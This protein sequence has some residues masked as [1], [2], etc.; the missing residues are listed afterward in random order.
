VTRLAL[1]VLALLALAAPAAAHLKPT[2]LPV[3]GGPPFFT[4][5]I[6]ASNVEH[7]GVLPLSTDSPGARLLGKHFYITTERDLT[8]YDVSN[9]TAPVELSR[10]LLT[11]APGQYYFPEEDVDTNGSVL[12]TSEA[13]AV[14][15]YDVSDKK[16]VK[17]VS[18]LEGDAQHTI[19]CVLD[20][21]WAYGSEG[22]IID[23]TD[24]K[25]PKVAGNW[26]TTYATTSRHDVTEVAPG[27]VLTASQPM[28]LLD[29]REDPA[30]PKLLARIANEDDRFQH[31]TLWPNQMQDKYA[32][33]GGEGSG[34]ACEESV[35]STFQTYDTT[36][37]ETSGT[38]RE[39]DQ[40]RVL[41][42]TFADGR[43]PTSQFCVHWFTP[44]PKYRNGGLVAISWYEHGTRIL[45][46]GGD[47]SI[48]EVGHVITP[49][50]SASAAYWIS[51]DVF[52]VAD[53]NRGLDIFKYTGPQPAAKK[54]KKPKK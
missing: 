32:L 51:D 50:S 42:G 3:L 52:Y 53:Y 4:P 11:D 22:S 16:D 24:P 35:D 29:A 30:K 23:L 44:H 6:T 26:E 20:C 19:S 1:A 25:A 21:T 14:E 28:Y 15:V 43:A 12:L 39:V 13:G 31:A 54:A 40:F 46:I 5:P 36:G 17:L 47:G 37:W 2:P 49:G 48:K 33:V 38:F 7:V 8:I 18:M 10:T 9:P 27:I 41:P 45:E 34:P